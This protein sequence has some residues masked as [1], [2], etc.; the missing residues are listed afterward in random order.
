[1]CLKDN[2]E[3]KKGHKRLR[4]VE[5]Q[6]KY[7]AKTDCLENHKNNE[8]HCDKYHSKP[9]KLWMGPVYAN[10]HQQIRKN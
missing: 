4:D 1:M 7:K 2:S 6:K 5:V 3:K 10:K 9:P 8:L